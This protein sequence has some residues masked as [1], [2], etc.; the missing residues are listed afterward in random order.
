MSPSIAEQAP[1]R[2]ISPSWGTAR[3][4]SAA[5]SAVTGLA[6]A[7]GI[8]ALTGAGRW[9]WV[10]VLGVIAL[11]GVFQI[12]N[13]GRVCRARQ[14]AEAG[15]ELLERHGLLSRSMTIVPYGRLQSVEVTQGP[16]ERLL[17]LASVRMQTASLIGSPVVRGLE[18]ADAQALADRLTLR[19]KERQWAQ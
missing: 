14:Y 7:S 16:Y 11:V 4:L 18:Q 10:G 5:V 1:W 9:W 3:R 13:S 15:D 19:A 2:G 8:L 17:G 12:G 6:A